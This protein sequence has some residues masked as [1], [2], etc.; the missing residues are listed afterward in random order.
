MSIG[1]CGGYVF[2]IGSPAVLQEDEVDRSSSGVRENLRS[3]SEPLIEMQVGG[4]AD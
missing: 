2:K 1:H 4:D 3:R